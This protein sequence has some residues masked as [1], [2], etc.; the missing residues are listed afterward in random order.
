MQAMKRLVFSGIV[1]VGL[2]FGSL[3]PLGVSA[4]EEGVQAESHAFRIRGRVE[5]SLTYNQRRESFTLYGA[6]K[7]YIE[8]GSQTV[9]YR[10]Y[11]YT[12]LEGQKDASGNIIQP[13]QL[14]HNQRR[15]VGTADCVLS[16]QYT[17][18]GTHSY[19][20]Y[21]LQVTITH[22]SMVRWGR[23]HVPKIWTKTG[24]ASFYPQP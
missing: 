18:P 13:T 16:E 3:T 23:G 24:W 21:Q 11:G 20:Y 14:Y 5:A 19:M 8:A 10:L 22:R 2:A 4:Q 9:E 1:A 7:G 17:G 6:G 12:G 15:C